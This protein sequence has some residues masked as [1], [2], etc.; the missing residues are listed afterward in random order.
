MP[1]RSGKRDEAGAERACRVPHALGAQAARHG[2]FGRRVCRI[3][4]S[5]LVTEESILL[6][7]L[8]AVDVRSVR[9]LLEK[10]GVSNI[11]V[12]ELL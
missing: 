9:A 6:S 8:P 5:G 10:R 4:H 12:V 2:R 7:D 1:P 3:L 11:R